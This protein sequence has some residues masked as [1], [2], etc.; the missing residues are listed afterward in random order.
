M[1]NEPYLSIKEF[2]NKLR[3]H[4][5]TIR[6]NIKKGYIQ[7]IKTGPGKRA[8]YRIANSELNRI[9]L[10]NLEEV[11]ERIMEKRSHT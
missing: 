4:P 11:I 7:A 8:A 3:V 5:Q 1:T 9:A 2:A 6:K 10:V